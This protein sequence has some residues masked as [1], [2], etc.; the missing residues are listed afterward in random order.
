MINL[1]NITHC[2][3]AKQ[4][5][6]YEYPNIINPII[7]DDLS[8][9]KKN[10]CKFVTDTKFSNY[11][12]FLLKVNLTQKKFSHLIKDFKIIMELLNND[13]FDEDELFK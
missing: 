13:V 12:G 4:A 6:I 10:F 2:P 7:E 1:G 3:Y 11:D 8:L 9:F 5:K